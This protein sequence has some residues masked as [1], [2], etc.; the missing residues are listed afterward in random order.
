MK[1]FLTF[2]SDIAVTVITLIIFCA[3]LYGIYYMVIK[4]K[5]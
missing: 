2:L 3:V 5:Q 4:T 1:K